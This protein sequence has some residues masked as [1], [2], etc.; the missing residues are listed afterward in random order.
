MSASLV[1]DFKKDWELFKKTNDQLIQAKADGKAIGDI[2]EKIAKINSAIEAKQTEITGKLAAM[3]TAMRRSPMGDGKQVDQNAA[4]HKAAFMSFVRKGNEAGLEAIQRKALAVNDDTAGGYM[5]H[6]DLTGR[7]IKHVFETSPVLAYAN[8]QTI[9]TDRLEG[10]MDINQA[11]SGGWVS[12][13]GTRSTTATPAIGRWDIP[14]HEQSAMPAATQKLL[15]DA[16]WDAEGWLADKIADKF[17]RDENYAFVL[18]TGVG[19]PHGFLS[20]DRTIV[21]D[22]GVTDDSFQSAKKIGYV[23]TG[24]SGDF[25]TSSGNGDCLVDT[26]QALKAEYRA[27]PGCAWAMN[28][29]TFAKVRK[30]KDQYGRYLWEPSFTAGMPAMLLGFPVA[31]F[32]DMAVAAA[33]S[34]SIAFANWK[35]AYQIVD[36][37]GI[38]VMRD[39]YSSKPYVLFYSTKRTGGDLLNFEA[40]KVVKFAAS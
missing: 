1:E 40:I 17:S 26:V 28:R 30:L 25:G 11:T 36:H 4:E 29:S 34:Y 14:V 23:P 20:A 32:N 9:S 12:E 38:R 31:E 33:N 21:A 22:S 15:D 7:I 2:E 3:E 16:A 6:A 35:E 18:G 5:V 39:P 27:R 37:Q 24:T 13:A 19:Q 10:I 8:V